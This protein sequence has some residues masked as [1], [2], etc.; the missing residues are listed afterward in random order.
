M[1][2]INKAS[3]CNIPLG[4]ICRNIVTN[5][6]QHDTYPLSYIECDISSLFHYRTFFYFF[7]EASSNDS[8]IRPAT[9]ST[10]IN[11]A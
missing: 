6:N 1:K 10:V 7:R 4:S 3:E 11:E 5:N 2:V 9:A 8:I